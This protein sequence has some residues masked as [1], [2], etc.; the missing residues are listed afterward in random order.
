MAGVAVLNQQ[1][2]ANASTQRGGYRI[3]A[4]LVHTYNHF[5]S[6]VALF[7]ITDRITQ[8]A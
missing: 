2:H 7:E 6:S 8:I 1:K 3:D 4:L 5:S